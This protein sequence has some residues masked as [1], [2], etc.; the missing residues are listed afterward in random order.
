[1]IGP[2][3][4]SA[5]P[6]PDPELGWLDRPGDRYLAL[7]PQAP[8][9][10]GPTEFDGWISTVKGHL[11]NGDLTLDD[12]QCASPLLGLSNLFIPYLREKPLFIQYIEGLDGRPE[13]YEMKWPPQPDP[14]PWDFRPERLIEQCRQ[15]IEVG[16]AQA[17]KV[18]GEPRGPQTPSSASD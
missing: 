4:L 14:V 16:Q 1:M 5:G 6:P 11:P 7:A 12:V 17:S 3:T 2:I 13:P 8:R 9:P 18:G 15:M 10:G